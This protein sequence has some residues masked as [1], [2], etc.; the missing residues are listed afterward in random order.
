MPP[1]KIGNS[2]LTLG[3]ANT[4]SGATTVSAGTV[5]INTNGA[6]NAADAG[7]VGEIIVGNT[8]GVRNLLDPAENV[9]GAARYLRELK[10]KLPARIAEPERTWMALAAGWLKKMRP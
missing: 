5:T 7:H 6:I 3:G 10:D 4:Y 8:A 2:T 9:L 1:T